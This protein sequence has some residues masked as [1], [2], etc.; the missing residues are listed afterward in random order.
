MSARVVCR[1]VTMF[2]RHLSFVCLLAIAAVAR[3]QVVGGAAGREESAGDSVD[4]VYVHDS[5]LAVEKMAHAQRMEGKQWNTASELYQE[6][7]EKFADRVVPSAGQAPSRLVRQYTSVALAVQERLAKWPVEALEVYRSMYE[8]AARTAFANVAT[9]DLQGMHR[10]I[11][12]YFIT[13]T[14]RDA[15]YTLLDRYL[16]SA[17]FSA[18]AWLGQRMVAVHP[19]LGD[20]RA[21]FLFRTALA[22]HFAGDDAGIKPYYDELTKDYPNSTDVVAGQETRLVDALSKAKGVSLAA[23]TALSADSW[24]MFGGSADR[25][26]RSGAVGQPGARLYGISYAKLRQPTAIQEEF[27]QRGLQEQVMG[28]VSPAS[29]VMPAVD[30]GELFFQDGANVYAVSLESGVP[31]PGWKE[32]Y[33]GSRNGQYGTDSPATNRSRQ[34]SVTLTDDA[35]LA[36]LGQT[37]AIDVAMNIVDAERAQSRLVCLDRSTG[38]ER[39][40]AQPRRLPEGQAALRQLD[41]TGS[42]IVAGDSVYVLGRSVKGQFEDCYVLCFSLRDGSYRWA[43]YIASA[44]ANDPFVDEMGMPIRLAESQLSYSGGRIYALTNLGALAALDGS[45]G[46]ILWLNI[47]ARP[48]TTAPRNGMRM[49]VQVRDRSMLRSDAAGAN[50]VIVS[51]G[52]VFA[53]PSDSDFILLY[54]VSTGREIK[55]ISRAQLGSASALIWA[56]GEELIT[57]GTM[58]SPKRSALVGIAYRIAWREYDAATFLTSDKCLLARSTELPV[59]RG[60]AFLVKDALLIPTDEYLAMLDIASFKLSR[61]PANQ[62]KWEPNEGRGNIVVAQDYVVIATQNGVDVYTDITLARKRLDVEISASPDSPLPR[63]RFAEIMFAAGEYQEALQRLTEAAD[64]LGNA[65]TSTSDGA[66]D[67]LFN[68]AIT[69]AQKLAGQTGI[70]SAQMAA[71]L[72]DRAGSAAIAPAQ[73]VSFLMNR[74]RFDM[75]QKRWDEAAARYQSVLGDTQLRGLGFTDNDA[76]GASTAGGVA[77]AQIDFIIRSG[78]RSAYATIE[79]AAQK[80]YEAAGGAI[81]PVR[82]LAVAETYPNSRVSAK[83]L[84]TAADAFETNGDYRRAVSV[85]RKMYLKSLNNAERIVALEALARSYLQI[86]GRGHVAVSRLRQIEQL[87][88]GTQHLTRPLRLSTGETIENVTVAESMLQLQKLLTTSG[89]LRALPDARIPAYSTALAFRREKKQALLP[90]RLQDD[91]VWARKIASI[92]PAVEGA[93]R[94]DRLVV[95][96]QSGSIQIFEPG[97][98]APLASSQPLL[99][100]PV[101]IA[102]VEGELQVWT[103]RSVMLLSG[104]NLDTLWAVDLANLPKIEPAVDVEPQDARVDANANVVQQRVI[105][106]GVAQAIIVPRGARAIQIKVNGGDKLVPIRGAPE[107]ITDV[108]VVDARVIGVTSQ[109]RI[110]AL[111]RADGSLAWQARPTDEPLPRVVATDDFCAI[112]VTVGVTTLLTAYDSFSGQNVYRHS[113]TLDANVALVNAGISPSG[114]LVGVLADRLFTKDLFEAGDAGMFESPPIDRSNDGFSIAAAKGHLLIDEDRVAVLAD[115]GK[116]VRVY[117]FIDGRLTPNKLAGGGDGSLPTSING[118]LNLLLRMYQN[119]LYM[120][121]DA[122]SSGFNLADVSDGWSENFDAADGAA[123]RQQLLIKDWMIAIRELPAVN[124]ENKSSTPYV[125]DFLSR[126]LRPQEQ[127]DRVAESGVLGYSVRIDEAQGVSSWAALSGGLAF[128]AGEGSL[129]WLA[130][131]S[132]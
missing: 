88:G 86:P 105:I 75:S 83:A 15:A 118:N 6:I 108:A 10:V 30:R 104:R 71:K 73:R 112:Q 57:T 74:A 98:P 65:P 131:T 91:T 36:V 69:F 72:Y 99:N 128:L 2:V 63:L 106:N 49:N 85:L 124:V 125:V 120:V 113:Y 87:G 53:L 41:F 111:D 26:R 110:F 42:P 9:D 25:A 61:F 44:N 84:L 93:E 1:S 17:E 132:E 33:G 56:S 62:A 82:L 27:R 14:A 127:I 79:Q 76:P 32:T 29:G 5:G 117:S 77:E 19:N 121:T 68:D 90:L 100:T 58:H 34:M 107:L 70:D 80:A 115:R 130:G 7:I 119:R 28:N 20:K 50:P 52:T 60:R 24:P 114:V 47:Y 67:R 8:P 35:V 123:T 13:D 38:R 116:T 59:I 92:L 22:M 95:L 96:T 55:R 122:A 102:W 40:I 46:T 43:S 11:S 101:G 51:D 97:T 39:W 81:D 129:H 54:D 103:D 45:S 4:G 31:L 18:A 37:S 89:S 64:L 48:G 21:G 66:R 78:G 126:E 109:G 12:T 94:H 23:P 3:A 16:E